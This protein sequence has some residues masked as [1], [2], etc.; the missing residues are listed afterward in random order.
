MTD[1]IERQRLQFLP[2]IAPKL[3]YYVY[4]VRD[5]RDTAS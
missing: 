4:A 3:G 2:G 1:S 5:P